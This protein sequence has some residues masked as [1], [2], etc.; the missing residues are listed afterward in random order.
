[1]M[2]NNI[3]SDLQT[4]PYKLINV[5]F[6]SIILAIFIYSAIFSPD[7]SNYP[8][9]S[10]SGLFSDQDSMSKGLSRSF[11]SIV[12]FKYSDARSYNQYGIQVFVFFLIQLFM[13]IFFLF[14]YDKYEDLGHKNIVIIDSMISGGLFLM[15][16]MPFFRQLI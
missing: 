2:R 1:M 3:F 10:E 14:S 12:R 9:Q 16:F 7:K 4:N 15:F 6:A 8:I 13:R 5:I 11:S